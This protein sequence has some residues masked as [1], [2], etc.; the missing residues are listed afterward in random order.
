MN[1][2]IIEKSLLPL[3]LATLIVIAFN[4]QFTQIYP[5]LVEHFT[6]SKLSILYSHLFIYTY[7]SLAIFTFITTVFNHYFVKSKLFVAVALISILLFYVFSYQILGDVFG[8]FIN[9]PLSSNAIMGMVLFIVGTISYTLYALGVLF[10]QRFMP[11]SHAFIFLFLA[12][13]YAALFI[14]HYCYPISEIMTK[15]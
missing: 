3:F 6:S 1:L 8:Y 13:I 10:T 2:K 14:N 12:L 5:F 15:F 11:L 9:V 4:W 7:L